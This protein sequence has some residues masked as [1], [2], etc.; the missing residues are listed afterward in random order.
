MCFAIAGTPAEKSRH[1]TPTRASSWPLR[2][3]TYYQAMSKCDLLQS[4]EP[5]LDHDTCDASDRL[6]PGSLLLFNN[7]TLL[8][9]PKACKLRRHLPWHARACLMNKHLMFIGDSLT[10]YQYVSLAHFISRLE[11]PD[12]YGG[13][14]ARPNICLE[15]EWQD[16]ESYYNSGAA[17]LSTSRGA[18]GLELVEADRSI[19]KENRMF[20]LSSIHGYP[21]GKVIL[22]QALVTGGAT[23][24]ILTLLQGIED[25]TSSGNFTGV[26]NIIV[27]NTGLWSLDCPDN[28]LDLISQQGNQLHRSSQGRVKLIWK[29]TTNWNRGGRDVQ[30]RA[31]LEQAV[32]GHQESF[33]DIFDAF[34]VSMSFQQ[35]GLDLYWDDLHFLPI[36][37]EILN[38]VLLNQLCPVSKR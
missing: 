23:Q 14:N 27:V 7:D 9:E 4:W 33:W 19:Y 31:K 28:D 24:S 29:T 20:S 12:Q 25:R 10:R 16:W 38:D 26:P 35:S 37:Y 21:H 18:Q 22:Q 1:H 6:W 13:D 34:E 2:T 32:F 17:I 8:Y 11:Y 30:D 15:R 36:G 3:A 5:P